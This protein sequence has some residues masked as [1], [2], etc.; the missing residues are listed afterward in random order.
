MKGTYVAPTNTDV[1]AKKH[2]Y[3]LVSV[4]I[5]SIIATVTYVLLFNFLTTNFLTLGEEEKTNYGID[6]KEK[7]ILKDDKIFMNYY[8]AFNIINI[9][10]GCFLILL[11]LLKIFSSFRVKCFSIKLFSCKKYIRF[12]SLHLDILFICIIFLQNLENRTFFCNI[13]NY[14]YWFEGYNNKGDLF[15]NAGSNLCHMHNYAFVFPSIF[16]FLSMIEFINLYLNT[17]KAFRK[18]FCLFYLK[19]FSAYLYLALFY[20][21][22][23]TQ[24]FFKRILSGYNIY[25][26]NNFSDTVKIIIYSTQKHK[27]Y[28]LRLL[29]VSTIISAVLFSL[30]SYYDL[31]GILRACKFSLLVSIL[32]NA[33]TLIFVVSQVLY[34]SYLLEGNLYFCSYEEYLQM[35][36]IHHGQTTKNSVALSNTT[37]TKW[38]CNLNYFLY[39]YLSNNFICL[40]TFI[41]DLMLSAYMVFSNKYASKVV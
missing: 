19:L 30:L 4:R 15:F 35:M 9:V 37:E 32:T 24:S 25:D 31:H 33:C 8:K 5:L 20:I 26:L 36:Q 40:L 38:F 6:D 3:A 28:Y 27:N 14:M 18:K 7:N 23:K 12:I 34:S 16:I 11:N 22:L 17:D 2:E 10:C 13:K 39:V 1:E 29:I 21:Y 41:A